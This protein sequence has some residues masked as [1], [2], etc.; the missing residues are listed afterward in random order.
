MLGRRKRKFLPPTVALAKVGHPHGVVRELEE[1]SSM[2][3][4]DEH[5][6]LL[7]G[8][9]QKCVGFSREQGREYGNSSLIAMNVVTEH[10]FREIGT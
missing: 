7:L 5:C 9:H 2:F 6:A 1:Y 8:L 4:Q 10:E 3:F